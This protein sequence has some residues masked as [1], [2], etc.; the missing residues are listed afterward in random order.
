[1]NNNFSGN[2]GNTFSLHPTLGVLS[3]NR[4]LDM[5]AVSEYMLIVKALDAGFPPLSST[6]PV[7]ILVVMSDNARPKQ[8]LDK[9]IQHVSLKV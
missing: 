3:L 5:T 6:L 7:H 1:M 8:V 2:V 4:E 9:Y